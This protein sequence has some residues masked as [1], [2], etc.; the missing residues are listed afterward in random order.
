MD[1]FFK[2]AACD[3]CHL[4]PHF[5]PDRFYEHDEQTL[6]DRRIRTD[7]RMLIVPTYF[8]TSPRS[9]VKCSRSQL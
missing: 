2:K 1:V 5:I 6:R 7:P 8:V 9:G 3:R 4:G